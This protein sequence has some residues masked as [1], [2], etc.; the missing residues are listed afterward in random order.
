MLGNFQA[1]Q[2]VFHSQAEITHKFVNTDHLQS[3]REA[4]DMILELPDPVTVLVSEEGRR[5]IFSVGGVKVKVC[6]LEQFDP[7]N[8][9]GLRYGSTCQR[10]AP[11]DPCCSP[12]QSM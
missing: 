5:G 7:C 9:R 2:S 8:D 1:S 12:L 3:C 10:C 6:G 11:T 4:N